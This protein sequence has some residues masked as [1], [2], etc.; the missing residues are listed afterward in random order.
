MLGSC[1]NWAITCIQTPR[2]ATGQDTVLERILQGHV[3]AM[4]VYLGPGKIDLLD[5]SQ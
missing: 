1:I 4:E 5:K 3:D 2:V